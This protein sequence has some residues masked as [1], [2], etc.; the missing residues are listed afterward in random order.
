MGSPAAAD[1]RP[2]AVGAVC[3]SPHAGGESADAGAGACSEADGGSD[4][5]GA[6]VGAR[7]ERAEARVREARAAWEAAAGPGAVWVEDE[8]ARGERVSGA[9]AASGGGSSPGG[10]AGGTQ[11]CP[12]PASPANGR[13]EVVCASS[14]PARRTS[15]AAFR[16]DLPDADDPLL[17][18]AP[19]PHVHP[20]RNSITADKQREFIAALAATG[21]VTQAAKAIGKSL[22]A[23]YK[24][25]QRPGAEGFREA[26]DMALDRGVS[27]L[28]DCALARAI[29]GEERPIV[30]SGE[31]LGWYRKHDNSLVQFFL[32]QRR[33]ERYGSTG[34]FE[35]LRP[36]HPVYDRLEQEWEARQTARSPAQLA[37]IRA[38]I[39]RKATGWRMEL[40]AAWEEERQALIA[41]GAR[42]V[43]PKIDSFGLLEEWD[44]EG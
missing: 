8:G 37:E 44:E 31:L 10:R 26:W 16:G 22:E 12:P 38:S 24:L 39:M 17:S 15:A 29:E 4:S 18:F 30:S 42:Y 19:V 28:E 3:E 13:G 36:G 41:S 33:P 14:R 34:R 2:L 9:G 32:R 5:L 7:R 43:P 40:E 21:I 20:R 6:G 25:R 35:D 23:L 27:R 1:P 11:G